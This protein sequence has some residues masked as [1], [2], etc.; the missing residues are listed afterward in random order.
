MAPL[1]F[2]LIFLCLAVLYLGTLFDTTLA[3]ICRELILPARPLSMVL[4]WFAA[5]SWA[6]LTHRDECLTVA[7]LTLPAIMLTSLVSDLLGTANISPEA[8]SVVVTVVVLA[9][10]FAITV[11]LVAFIIRFQ[12][13][14]SSQ[15]FAQSIAHNE[16]PH[17]MSN[18]GT[19]IVLSQL[20]DEFGLSERETELMELICA[21]NTQKRIAEKMLVSI[22]S[23]QTY[24]KSLYRKLDIH[25]KQELIDLVTSRRD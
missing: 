15:P 10:S 21:G 2:T 12:I 11:I 14:A 9:C 13:G 24:A 8:L 25:S 7:A 23:V 5:L 17:A 18:E 16:G 3:G 19:D 1:W 20:R 22:N 4:L 6:Q